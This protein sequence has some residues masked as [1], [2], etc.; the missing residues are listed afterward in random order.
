MKKGMDMFSLSSIYYPITATPFVQSRSY[1]EISP[2][3]ALAPYIRCFWGSTEPVAQEKSQADRPDIVIPDTCMDIIFN[4]DHTSGTVSSCFCALD[5]R[6]HFLDKT[7]DSSITSTFAIRFYAWSAVLF[8]DDSFAE[9]KNRAFDT[10]AFFFGLNKIMIPMLLSV[11]SLQHRV[12]FC[13]TY[14][15]KR[16]DTFRMN[17]DMMNVL[18]DMMASNGKQKIADICVRNVVSSRKLERIFN[19]NMGI[20]PKSMASLIRYQ[21]LWQE[22]C[23]G[24][25]YNIHDLVEKYGYFDQSH[26]LNE[27]RKRHAM[28]PQQALE[29]A[30]G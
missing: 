25:N 27:F 29:Y 20:S 28:T 16:L 10:D 6:T 7:N 12:Q 5:E 11:T 2:S 17:D 9:S 1:T 21:M 26:L 3:A 24:K 30:K 13:S 14:L 15:I 19:E 4:I 23:C 22:L 8:A 18:F